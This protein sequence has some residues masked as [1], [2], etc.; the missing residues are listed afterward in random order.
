MLDDL[1]QA[2]PVSTSVAKKHV[3]IA[4]NTIRVVLRQQQ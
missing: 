2:S 1:W 4:L 3:K